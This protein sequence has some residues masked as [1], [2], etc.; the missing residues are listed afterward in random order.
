MING[1]NIFLGALLLVVGIIWLLNNLGILPDIILD[2]VLS[3]QMLLIVIGGYLMA[4]RSW[5]AG[6]IIAAVGVA[7]LIMDL[8]G[9]YVSLSKVIIPTILIAAG[10]SVIIT[11]VSCFKCKNAG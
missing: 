2:T 3:W 8:A 5:S 6:V 7:F 11:N 4:I 1:R 9:V 10:A